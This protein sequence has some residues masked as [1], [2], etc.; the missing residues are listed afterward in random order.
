M[1]DFIARIREMDL[2]RTVLGAALIIGVGLIL[3]KILLGL[4]KKALLRTGLDESMHK[5]ILNV[6]KAALY[7]VV[8]VVLLAH[9]NVPTAPLV[10]V[11]GAAGAAIA[12]ALKDSLGNIAGGVL[13]L[14][15]KPFKKGDV[16][17]VAGT[18]GMVDSIDLFVTTLKTFDNKVV[19][20]PNGSV[21]TSV[22]VN[23][24]RENMRRVD[25]VFDVSYDS[26]ISAAK[27]VLLAVAERCPDAYRDPAPIVGVNEH[28]GSSVALDLKVWCETSKYYDVQYFLEEEVIAEFEKANVTIPYPRMDVRVK[29]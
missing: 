9:L 4:A 23:Y 11:L 26:D 19:T 12:L 27:D 25:C 10:T 18:E 14:A 6:F 15:N 17:D 20:V 5:F 1:N 24:S 13:I 21:T 29:K 8:I 22:I 3:I 7:V 16:I 28:R 2:L